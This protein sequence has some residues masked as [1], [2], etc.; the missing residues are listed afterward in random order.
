MGTMEQTLKNIKFP[1]RREELILT[2]MDL[3]NYKWQEVVYT[4]ISK[5]FT[6]SLNGEYGIHYTLAEA[7]GI[8]FDE[9]GL[10]DFLKK[11][12]YPYIQIGIRLKSRKEA[13]YLY[14]VAELIDKLY[15]EIYCP[16]WPN[17]VKAKNCIYL[18]SPYLH[19]LRK[20]SKEAFNVFMNN[21]NDNKEFIDY[22]NKGEDNI[23][24]KYIKLTQSNN[25]SET[26][27]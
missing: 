17:F 4:S 22:L 24:K 10:D 23:N 15:K 19:E 13:E 25:T 9:L 11:T 21:E 12:Q 1:E 2:L 18:N 26:R 7:I 14:K 6:T 5:N 27:I 16:N 3:S 8:I 20:M